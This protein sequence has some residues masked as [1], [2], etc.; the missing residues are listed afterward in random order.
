MKNEILYESLHGMLLEM[1]DSMNEMNGYIGLIM[2]SD[3]TTEDQKEFKRLLELSAFRLQNAI[4][5]GLDLLNISAGQIKISISE[6]N[7][8]DLHEQVYQEFQ[9]LAEKTGIH[10]KAKVPR[11]DPAFVIQTDI[12]SGDHVEQYDHWIPNFLCYLSYE[13]RAP[14]NHLR[15]FA[16]LLSSSIDFPAEQQQNLKLLRDASER[17]NQIVLNCLEPFRYPR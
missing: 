10:F 5:I 2:D 13:I 17:I 11:L 4:R 14:N 12:D 16:E 7:I 3:L 15:A 1:S 9:P 8:H 6:T